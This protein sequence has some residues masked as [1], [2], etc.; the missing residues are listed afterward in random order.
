MIVAAGSESEINRFPRRLALCSRTFSR[1]G[2][3]KPGAGKVLRLNRDGEIEDV[4]T[5]LVVPTGMTFGPDG[6]LYVSNFGA[7]LQERVR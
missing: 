5:G 7:A 1:A 2:L 6:R 3:S 4:A